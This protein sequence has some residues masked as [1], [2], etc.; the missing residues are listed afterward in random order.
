[1]QFIMFNIFTYIDIVSNI[2]ILTYIIFII[3]L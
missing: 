3:L 2:V 1:M